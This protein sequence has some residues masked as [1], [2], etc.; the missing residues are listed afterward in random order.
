MKMKGLPLLFLTLAASSARAEFL[1]EESSAPTT[2]KRRRATF[3]T[4]DDFIFDIQPKC[5]NDIPDT[6]PE[7]VDCLFFWQRNRSPTDFRCPQ[8]DRCA[9]NPGF[10]DGYIMRKWF[11][12][13]NGKICVEYCVMI[14]RCGNAEGYPWWWSWLKFFN[15]C[16]VPD[17]ANLEEKANQGWKCGRCPA[18]EA[19]VETTPEPTAALVTPEPAPAP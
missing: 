15:F 6:C 1:R 2:T 14:R 7:D 12:R 3:D 4:N 10:A 18:E 19:P 13:R 17:Y 16:S 8:S 11:E 5:C 9:N